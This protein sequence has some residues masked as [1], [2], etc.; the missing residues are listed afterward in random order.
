MKIEVQE[1]IH[2]IC[3][4]PTDS[5]IREWRIPVFERPL[6]Y[7]VSTQTP[8]IELKEMELKFERNKYNQWQLVL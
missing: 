8:N 5:K 4:L 3:K 1:L 2:E 6:I 7:K